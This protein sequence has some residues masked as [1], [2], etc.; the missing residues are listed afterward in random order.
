MEHQSLYRRYRPGRFAEVRGQRHVVRALQNAVR[1]DRVGHAYLLS[2]PRGTGKTTLARILAKVL[3]CETP[4]DGEPCG[5]CASCKA[6]QTGTSFDLHELDAA[7]NNKVDDMRDLLAKVALGTPGRT[8]V[9]LLDEVHMLSAGA[10]NALLKTLEEPPDHV[11]F[12]LAT[13]EPHKVVPTVRSRTQHLELTLLGADE[14]AEHIRWVAADA[15]LDVD[16]L[17]VDYVVRAGG[18]SVRDALS[19]LDQVMAAGGIAVDDTSTL[20]LLEALASADAGR[21]LTA[22]AEATRLGRD[23]RVVG[24]TLLDALRDVFLVAM[25]VHAHQITD[26]AREQATAFAARLSPASI[27]RALE[28]IGTALVDMR[29]A[30]DPRVDLEVALVR[31]TRVGA[32]LSAEALSERLARLERLVAAG[33]APPGAAAAPPAATPATPAP[34]RAAGPP[35]PPRRST[36]GGPAAEARSRLGRAGTESPPSVAAPPP[37]EP[38]PAPSRTAPPPPARPTERESPAAPAAPTAAPPSREELS[39]AWPALLEGLPKG[40]RARYAAARIAD[41]TSAGVVFAF[42]NEVHRARCEQLRPEV[43][44]ALAARFGRPVP[45]RL[46]ADDV[47]TAP[48]RGRRANEPVEPLPDEAIDPAELTDAPAGGGVLDQLTTAFPGA[49]LID[50]G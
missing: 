41:S 8:K 47:A 19:A 5:V 18:G 10:E 39:A 11:V 36:A 38:P 26:R 32:D 16:D 37:A 25:G 49:E 6:I 46:V 12:L 1:D 35:P 48:D 31:L 13:T 17:V 14:M 29:Q 28:L 23:P 9:Y 44:A 34:A 7:S 33:G 20:E 40:V 3:N 21:A 45:L 50:E 30:P 42:P 15:G 4:T 43:E 2:G 22:V 27:T 24:E